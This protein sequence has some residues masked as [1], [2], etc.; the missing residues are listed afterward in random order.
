MLRKPNLHTPF[1]NRLV[2]FLPAWE[3]IT[4]D[5]WISEVV[6]TGYSI[7]FHIILYSFPFSLRGPIAAG[8]LE[9]RIS[10]PLQSGSDRASFPRICGKSLLLQIFPGSLKKQWLETVSRHQEPEHLYPFAAF[11]DGDS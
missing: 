8:S 6:A 5:R 2:Y 3:L 9:I 10:V 7:H 11:Q 1:G 4:M